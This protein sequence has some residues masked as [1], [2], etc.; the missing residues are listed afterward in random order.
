MNKRTENILL[1]KKQILLCHEVQPSIYDDEL[2]HIQQNFCG[3]VFRDTMPITVLIDTM[4]Y[5]CGNITQI[6]ENIPFSDDHQTLIIKE[7]SFN[8]DDFKESQFISLGQVPIN[9][10]NVGVFFRKFFDSATDY[11]DS[12]VSEHE[13]QSLTES[14]KAGTSYRKGIYLTK[15]DKVENIT[16]FKLLRCSTNF[17]GPTDNLRETDKQIISHVND[18]GE[19]FFE[20]KSELN[21]VLAQTYHNTTIG[22]GTET[23]ERKARIAEHSDKTKDMPKNALIAFCT[24]YKDYSDDCFHNLKQNVKKSTE[25]PYDYRYKQKTTV[26]TKLRFRLKK[27]ITDPQ[28]VESFDVTLYP[29]SVFIISLMTNRLY[30]HEIVPSMLPIDLLPTRMGYVIRCSDTDAVH[31]DNQTHIVKDSEY[32]KLDEP[33]DQGIVRLKELYLIENKTTEMVYYDGFHFSLNKG[34]YM[35]PII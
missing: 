19:H 30:T 14:N 34:D 18:I 3:T 28:Y 4:I 32:I 5:L 8:C 27:D 6:Y 33:T 24:F 20:G 12:I 29:N 11:Y 10:H 25:D 31:K 2:N 15:V 35:E 9:V 21:H 13:F 7:L 17:C 16:A 23:K 1:T 22:D 26:L